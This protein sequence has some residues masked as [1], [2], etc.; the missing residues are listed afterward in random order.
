[1]LLDILHIF[2]VIA[3]QGELQ[4]SVVKDLSIEHDVVIGYIDK[5]FVL[6]RVACRVKGNINVDA[7]YLAEGRH[8]I[9]H[10]FFCLPQSYV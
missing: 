3:R 6:I 8:S 10:L 4:A 5:K 9:I 1:M 7:L 2:K